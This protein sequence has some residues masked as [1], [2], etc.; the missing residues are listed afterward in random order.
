MARTI[1]L[2]GAF[3]SGK[4]ITANELVEP[5]P[6]ARTFD[7]EIVGFM[8][9]HDTSEPVPDFRDRPAWRAL[10][11]QAT[12]QMPGHGGGMPVAPGT[13]LRSDCITGILDDLARRGIEHDHVLPDVRE[14]E[15][16]RRIETD[17]IE[18]GARQWRLDHVESHRETAPGCAPFPTSWTRPP[19]MPGKPPAPSPVGWPRGTDGSYSPRPTSQMPSEVPVSRALTE[20]AC[21]SVNEAM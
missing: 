21:A 12:D 4:S 8:L 13:V 5:V 1:W 17:T 10:V 18:T 2:N 19:W 7:R 3:G 20:A 9:R 16:V 6:G 15:L 11:P 14:D